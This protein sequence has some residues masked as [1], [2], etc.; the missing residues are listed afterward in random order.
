MNILFFKVKTILII[1]IL[2]IIIVSYI[3]NDFTKTNL[4]LFFSLIYFMTIHQLLTKLCFI[5]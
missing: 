4:N 1:T 5:I 3:E 2:N